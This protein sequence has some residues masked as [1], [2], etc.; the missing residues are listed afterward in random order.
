GAI[1]GSSAHFRR[2]AGGL[3]LA[4]SLAGPSRALAS[5]FELQ[6]SVPADAGDHFHLA[7]DGEVPGDGTFHARLYMSEAYKALYRFT[8]P[9]GSRQD[10]V[11]SQLYM[12]VGAAY[13][14]KKVVLFA[15]DMPFVPYQGGHY[16]VG[17]AGLGDLRLGVRGSFVNVPGFSLGAEG[18]LFL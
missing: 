10:L 17:S 4:L 11:S 16:G 9:D 1:V 12:N 18:R 8:A 5:G 15:L 7:P 14:L 6:T 3:A 13:A 2:R